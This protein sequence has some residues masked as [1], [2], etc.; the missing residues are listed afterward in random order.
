LLLY[1]RP[2]FEGGAIV[3]TIP[4]L[5][6][7]YGN[8]W[9]NLDE[10]TFARLTPKFG[11]RF[12][13]TILRAGKSVF[14]GTMPYARTFGEV[15]AGSPLLYLNSLMNVAF[16]LNQGNFARQHSIASGGEWSVRVEKLAP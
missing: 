14:T 11:D 2:R 13:V 16:A 7:Q 12:R 8:V 3:G 1:E 5:D 9:T 4:F 6:F 15:A 10:A